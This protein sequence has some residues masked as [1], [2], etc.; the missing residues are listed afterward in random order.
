MHCGCRIFKVAAKVEKFPRLYALYFDRQFVS[1]KVIHNFLNLYFI[2]LFLSRKKINI[3]HYNLK[4]GAQR[5]IL[6]EHEI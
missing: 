6:Y 4:H 2:R 5:F 1:E 3:P